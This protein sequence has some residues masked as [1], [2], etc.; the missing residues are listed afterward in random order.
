MHAIE[1]AYSGG[2][3]ESH[4]KNKFS[5][6]LFP[7][8]RLSFCLPTPKRC[9]KAFRLIERT[10]LSGGD[11]RPEIEGVKGYFEGLKIQN[12]LLAV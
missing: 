9:Y 6:A 12:D 2:T 3:V 11:Y 5:Q 8:K 10:V 4:E 7:I 1:V